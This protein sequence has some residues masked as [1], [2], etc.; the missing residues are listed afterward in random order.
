VGAITYYTIGLNGYLLKALDKVSHL[1]PSAITYYNT[2]CSKPSTRSVT[3]YHQPSPITT[4]PAQSPR[5]GQSPITISHHLLQHHLL[6]ALD[7]VSHLLPSAITYYNTTCSKPSTRS[8]T[9]YHQPSPITTPPAQSSRQGQSPITIS[10]H[11]LQHHLLKALDKV[12]HQSLL[13]FHLDSSYIPFIYLLIYLP[14]YLNLF[15]FQFI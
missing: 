1:L 8:V 10:H 11:L 13:I 3:F 14:Q 9:F 2:T 4:P 6:K 15:K 5:Q 7:K 12:S